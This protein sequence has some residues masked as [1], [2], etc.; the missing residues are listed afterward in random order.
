MW[1]F[2][3]RS[4]VQKSKYLQAVANSGGSGGGGGGCKV[5]VFTATD[6]SLNNITA[7]MTFAE[8]FEALS[9][10]ELAN[11][12]ILAPNSDANNLPAY[13]PL[14]MW[15]D[16]SAAFG[17]A[18]IFFVTGVDKAASFFWTSNGFHTEPPM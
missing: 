14:P 17:V 5:L 4:P 13:M 1:K 6:E 3:N 8:A 12:L 9:K 2:P 11:A 15:C 18:C 7:N 16:A 10:H